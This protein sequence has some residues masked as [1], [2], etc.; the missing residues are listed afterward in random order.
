MIPLQPVADEEIKLLHFIQ[1]QARRD[2]E[3]ALAR[4]KCIELEENMRD[5]HD[6]LV[7]VGVAAVHVIRVGVAVV[8]GRKS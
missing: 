4:R 7:Y 6:R 3:I 8:A 1:E 2:A 5:Y